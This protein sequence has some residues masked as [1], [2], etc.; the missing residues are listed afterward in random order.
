MPNLGRD[1]LRK[2]ASYLN[3]YDLARFGLACKK[4]DLWENFLNNWIYTKKYTQHINKRNAKL[5]YMMAV[6]EWK[7]FM[8]VV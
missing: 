4:F 3:V 8:R 7:R 1:I 2:I 5:I 6:R